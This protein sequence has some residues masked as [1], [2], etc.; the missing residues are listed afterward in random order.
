MVSSRPSMRPLFVCVDII[1][2]SLINNGVIVFLYDISH[3]ACTTLDY[4]IVTQE[5]DICD[6][7]RI[8]CVFCRQKGHIFRLKYNDYL[9]FSV[10]VSGRN[11][12]MKTPVALML[13]R[14]E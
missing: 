1:F 3:K 13:L 8:K 12:R 2:T 7:I 10:E 5:Q 14:V 4:H 11:A 9:V 6:Q